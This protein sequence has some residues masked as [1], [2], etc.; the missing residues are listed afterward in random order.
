MVFFLTIDN[1]WHPTR[2]PI[3]N[4]RSTNTGAIDF[5]YLVVLTGRPWTG[6]RRQELYGSTA[7]RFWHAPQGD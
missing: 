5:I 4:K 2:V 6:A 1:L 3:Q 7:P